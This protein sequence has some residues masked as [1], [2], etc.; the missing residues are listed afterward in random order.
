MHYF[1]HISNRLGNDFGG[2]C[3]FWKG[4]SQ[5]STCLQ[6]TPSGTETHIVRYFP[7]NEN[8]VLEENQEHQAKQISIAQGNRDE[9][10]AGTPAKESK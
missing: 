6:K 8:S 4:H 3:L 9:E 10:E 5:D 7:K 2:E 1:T